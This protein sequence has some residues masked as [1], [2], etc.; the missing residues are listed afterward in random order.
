MAVLTLAE[1]KAHL[2]I[3]ATTTT[4]DSELTAFITSAE[5]AIAALCGPLESTAKTVRVRGGGDALA[6]PYAPAVSLT[7]VTPV[8]STALT[9]GDLYLDTAA[10]VVTY[11]EGGTFSSDRYTVVYQAGRSTCPADLLLAVKE[12]VRHLWKSSQRGGSTRP[13]SGGGEGYS[14]TLPG[15]AYALPFRVTELIAPHLQPGFA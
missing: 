11:D 9:L 10:A 14:N 3:P 6:L 4:H 8:G 7:S 2:N 1:A 12:L 15:A 13:G 5:A